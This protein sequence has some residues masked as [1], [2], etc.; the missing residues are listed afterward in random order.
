MHIHLER[1]NMCMKH[2]SINIGDSVVSIVLDTHNIHIH[3]YITHRHLHFIHT[4][5]ILLY[6]RER[7]MSFK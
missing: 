1:M 7:E 4:L 6:M 2:R 3:K 5:Y